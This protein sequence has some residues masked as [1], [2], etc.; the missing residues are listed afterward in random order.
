MTGS[1]NWFVIHVRR[2][3]AGLPAIRLHDTPTAGMVKALELADLLDAAQ[4]ESSDAAAMAE[5]EW[6][7]LAAA[8]RTTKPTSATRAMVLAFPMQRE[9]VRAARRT[10]ERGAQIVEKPASR[11]RPVSPERGTPLRSATWAEVGPSL[12]TRVWPW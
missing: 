7:L 3:R 1:A 4:I 11:Q 9:A 5:A 6:K 2:Q 12:L 10:K 8:A